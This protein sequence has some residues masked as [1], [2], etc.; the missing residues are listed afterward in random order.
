[1]NITVQTQTNPILTL[2]SRDVRFF[3]NGS[4]KLAYIALELATTTQCRRNGL[5]AKKKLDNYT[6]VS[7]LCAKQSLL[8]PI[9][10]GT[11]D[12]YTQNSDSIR[13]TVARNKNRLTKEEVELW[14]KQSGQGR[15]RKK[16]K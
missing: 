3:Y 9:E 11:W 15:F 14:L 2:R 13:V 8:I 7:I 12:N 4:R 1:M 16:S 10:Q 5:L 6:H